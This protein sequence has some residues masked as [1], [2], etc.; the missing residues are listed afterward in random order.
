MRESFWVINFMAMA[1]LLI[2]FRG[3][4]HANGTTAFPPKKGKYNTKVE[5]YIMG[6]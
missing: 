6:K 5:T 4:L 3:G 2:L 1:F